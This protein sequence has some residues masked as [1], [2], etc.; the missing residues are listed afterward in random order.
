MTGGRQ[1]SCEPAA[2]RAGCRC[3]ASARVPAPAGVVEQREGAPQSQ[4]RA[5][6]RACTQASGEISKLLAIAVQHDRRPQLLVAHAQRRERHPA[7]ASGAALAA[8]RRLAGRRHQARQLLQAGV[9]AAAVGGGRSR[10][11]AQPACLPGAVPRAAGGDDLLQLI[12]LWPVRAAEAV[13]SGS[14]ERG[15]PACTRRQLQHQ[16]Q[17]AAAATARTRNFAE[18]ALHQRDGR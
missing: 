7:V 15:R 12:V 2:Q 11:R 6:R 3:G 4:L 13:A 8:P 18:A 5:E 16:P 1:A 14:S 17:A 10:K 9:V